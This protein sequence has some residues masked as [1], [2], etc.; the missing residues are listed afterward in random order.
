M[1][2]NKSL[3]FF[4]SKSPVEVD[5]FVSKNIEI[6]QKVFELLETKGWT[7]K[8][9]SSRIRKSETEINKWLTGLHNFSLKNIIQLEIALES[10]IITV[11]GYI[12]KHKTRQNSSTKTPA[13][14]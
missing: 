12:K 9:L 13:L 14:L 2:K 8:D 6:T 7:T 10:D 4:T 5:K 1:T 3:E 11:T